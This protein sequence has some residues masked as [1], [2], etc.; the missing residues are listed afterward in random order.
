MTAISR[1]EL[2][3]K[4]Q[5]GVPRL[6]VCKCHGLVV[7]A[8]DFDAFFLLLLEAFDAFPLEDQLLGDAKQA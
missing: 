5:G 2:L 1:P 3:N 7:R 6:K 8:M 4:L